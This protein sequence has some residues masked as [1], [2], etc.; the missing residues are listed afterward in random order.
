LSRGPTPLTPLGV[1][2]IRAKLPDR[3]RETAKGR[4]RDGLGD[5][6]RDTVIKRKKQA[7]EKWRQR[8][9]DS[10]RKMERGRQRQG[11]IDRETAIGRQREG[12]SDGETETGRQR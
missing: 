3:D 5:T 6:A 8:Q 9:G 1:A 2:V 12:D 11:V 10:D 4:R 7:D